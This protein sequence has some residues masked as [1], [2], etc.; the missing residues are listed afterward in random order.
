MYM[1]YCADPLNTRRPD[2]DYAAEV[3]AADRLG[4]PYGLIQYEALVNADDPG[5]AVRGI[6]PVAGPEVAVYRGWMLRP[7][8][9]T[10]LYGAL[11]DRGLQLINDPT[12]YRHTHYLPE[13]YVVIQ[14]VTPRTVWLATGPEVDM[15]R[16]MAVLHGLGDGPVIVKD[17]VKSE[18]HEWATACYIPSAA[19]RP[20]VERVVRRFLA[21]RGPDLNEGLVFR[22]FVPFAP[23]ATHPQSGMPLSKEFRVFYLDGTPLY[24]V[25]YW[26]AG[27]Y[28][29]STPPLEPFKA[30]ATAVQ[31]R[32]FT[33][34]VAQH[35]NG[36]WLIVELGDGQ[37]AGLPDN[38]DVA[39]YYR[40]L[41]QRVGTDQPG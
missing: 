23:L 20:A 19:D 41:Q 21:L 27:D 25:P 14:P 39:A 40:A 1:I 10:L 17:F 13:S 6:A 15:D 7:A 11:A 34:D 2:P 3:A 22:A 29:G 32:F 8:A 24:T 33:M 18:K 35:R 9:Y 36:G 26:D 28:T 31:S 12:A 30:V 16:V 38:A 37:V 5:R 4:I